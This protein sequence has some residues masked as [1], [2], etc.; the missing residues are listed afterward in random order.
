[1]I[2]TTLDLILLDDESLVS[3][4]RPNLTLL[5][6]VYSHCIVGFNLSFFQPG[7]ESVRNALLNC[8]SPKDYTRTKYPM[9]EHDWPCHGKPETLVVDNGVEF[10]SS[11]LEQSCLELGINIQYNPVRK[12]WLKPMMKGYLVPLIVSF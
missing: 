7:Y 4:G 11:S 12:P 2:D 6:D 5:I 9:I 10:W 1:M 8:I 3:I